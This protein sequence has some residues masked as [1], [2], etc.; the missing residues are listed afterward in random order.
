MRGLVKIL[1]IDILY[2]STPGQLADG[3]HKS[4]TKRYSEFEKKVVG[5]MTFVGWLTMSYG[6]FVYASFILEL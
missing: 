5:C 6:D 1:I 3:Q 2:K 4:H